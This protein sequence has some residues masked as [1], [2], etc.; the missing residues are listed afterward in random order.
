MALFNG[1]V[2][3]GGVGFEADDDPLRASPRLIS[4]ALKAADLAV[5]HNRDDLREVESELTVPVQLERRV[6]PGAGVDLDFHGASPLP[7]LSDGP[8][9]LMVSALDQARG[10]LDY[11]AAARRL[12]ARAPRAEFLHVGPGGEGACALPAEVLRSYAGTVKFLGP[13]EDVRGA[14]ARCHAFVYPSLR[15]GMPRAVLE[16]LAAGRPV[17]TTAVPGCRET[18]D[19]CVNGMLVAPNN[20]VALEDAMARLLKRPDLMAS[21]ARAS[22]LKAERHFD[23]RRVLAAWR[24]ILGM[25]QGGAG[26]TKAEAATA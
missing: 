15:E 11:C 19:D 8:V 22:R 6:V 5:F 7:S 16:A 9:F 3:R 2:A 17:I 4:R 21:M 18:V 12:K 1:F 20:V 26:R 14:L 23:E 13:Q 25:D 10:V 24:D